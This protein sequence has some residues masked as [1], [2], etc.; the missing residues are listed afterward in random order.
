M[1]K[2]KYKFAERVPDILLESFFIVVALLLALALDQWRDEQKGLELAKNAKSAIYAELTDNKQKLDD[3][4]IAHEKI[5]EAI[6]SYIKKVDEK[7]SNANELEFEYTMVLI[8]SSAWNSAKMTQVV[9]S[10]SF[11]E[12]TSFSQMYQM[13][14][15]YLSNQDKIIDKVMEMGELKEDELHGFAKGLSH[16]LAILIEINKSFSKGLESVI[17]QSSSS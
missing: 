10:F 4:I 7:E 12:I 9:Q 3:K 2:L 16:R 1:T 8:S 11:K 6:N 13:Q 15:L 14:D 5:L 17:T